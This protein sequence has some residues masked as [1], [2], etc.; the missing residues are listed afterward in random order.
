ML[1]AAVTLALVYLFIGSLLWVVL[2]GLGVM[3]R[4]YH[5]RRESGIP[6]SPVQMVLAIGIGIV[7]WPLVSRQLLRHPRKAGKILYKRFWGV[8]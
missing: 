2:D 3:N 1:H 7:A 5:A 6:P 8:R 4:A